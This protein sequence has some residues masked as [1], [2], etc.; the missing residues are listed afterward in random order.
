MSE[1]VYPIA[2]LLKDDPRYRLEAYQFV[3]DGLAYGQ[4][5][6]PPDAP[7][8]APPV[9]PPDAPPAIAEEVAPVDPDWDLSDEDSLPEE[10][11]EPPPEQEPV[12]W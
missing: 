12:H 9:A 4:N 7:P 10:G 5:V 2:Q 3:R 11:W 8:D 6:A 1:E